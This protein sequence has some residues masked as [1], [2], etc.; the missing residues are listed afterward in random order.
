MIRI[1]GLNI[2]IC[3]FTKFNFIRISI[4]HSI[5]FINIQIIRP[6]TIEFRSCYC[7]S[8]IK[9]FLVIFFN[10]DSKR[11]CYC[12]LFSKRFKG[13]VQS[14]ITTYRIFQVQ[15][16]ITHQLNICTTY[17]SPRIITLD[18]LSN[19]LSIHR[20]AISQSSTCRKNKT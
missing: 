19:I 13:I 5:K 18:N 3:P 6:C 16:R 8:I 14:T 2:I 20:T 15:N 12:K 1:S 7:R 11:L 9:Q 10:I 17:I 4:F